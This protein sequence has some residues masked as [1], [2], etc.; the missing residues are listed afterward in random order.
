M[1]QARIHPLTGALY[2]VEFVCSLHVCVR[3]LPPTVQ[4]HT[5][6]RLIGDWK[7]ALGVS[8]NGCLYVLADLRPVHDV[9]HL[10]PHGTWD[11]LLPPCNPK[12]DKWKNLDGWMD[13]DLSLDF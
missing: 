6:L 3:S 7:L 2:C 1:A 12:L 13:P 10:S 4:R 5:W 9:P 11:R 8:V